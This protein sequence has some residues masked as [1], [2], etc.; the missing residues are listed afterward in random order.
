MFSINVWGWEN[1]NIDYKVIFQLSNQYSS[2]ISICRRAAVFTFVLL[3]IVLIYIIDRTEIPF[4][5]DVFAYVPMHTLPLICWIGLIGYI[6]FPFSGWFN[7]EARAYY[8]T[9]FLQSAGSIFVKIDFRHVWLMEQI[10]SFIGPL[11]DAEYAG[12]YYIHYNAPL[13]NIPQICSHSRLISLVIGFAPN[14]LR[15]LQCIRIIIDTKKTNFQVIN[16][17]KYIINL[18]VITFSFH[19]NRGFAFRLSWFG[20]VCFGALY[21]FI[22]D[23]V[24]DF[25][26]LHNGNGYPLREKLCYPSKLF[27]YV[28]AVIDLLL[29]FSW[30]V[31]LS[32]EVMHFTYRPEIVG[33]TLF[34]LEI[35]RRGLWN[36]IRVECKHIEISNEYRVTTDVQLPYPTEEN[37][38]FKINDDNESDNESDNE[39]NMDEKPELFN[40]IQKSTIRYESRIIQDVI[41]PGKDKS[42]AKKRCHENKL[43]HYL[44]NDYYPKSKINLHRDKELIRILSIYN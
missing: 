4:L 5:F 31:I 41:T 33:L 36:A 12:C 13:A 43:V 27:Y 37:E 8:L 24:Y 34:V 11:R 16:I 38:Y 9:L 22:W 20:L 40:D 17:V 29:R 25:G 39:N 26:L 15:I 10:V 32:P 3:T 44:V 6:L 18:L 42:N 7:Y 30:F 35:V 1:Y 23:I 28:A 2:L 14:I 19:W 21:S